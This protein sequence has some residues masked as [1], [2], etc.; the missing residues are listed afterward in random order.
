MSRACSITEQTNALLVSSSLAVL[1][2][3]VKVGVV[4]SVD[5][6]LMDAVVDADADALVLLD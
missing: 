4:L 3:I 5:V 2:G 6:G 1:V